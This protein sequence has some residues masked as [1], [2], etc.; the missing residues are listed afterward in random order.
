[1][2]VFLVGGTGLLGSAAAEELIRR[3]HSVSA[4]ALPPVPEGTALP[5]Q[6]TLD[7]KSYLTLSDDEIRKCMDGCEGFVFASGIDERMG[8]P[9]PI[10]DFFN[11]YNVAPLER[12]LRI[13]KECGVKHSVV[14]GSYFSYFDKIWP[15]LELYR[16]HPYIRSR[17]EQEKMALSFADNNF[18]VAIMELPYIF[19]GQQGREPVWTIIVKTLRGMKGVT[20]YP[21]GGTTMVTKKQVAQAIAGALEKTKGGQCWPIGWYNMSWKEFLSIVHENMGMPGRKI[22]TIPNWMLN[23]GIKSIEKKIREEGTEGGIYMPKFADLQSA[24]TF[25]DKSL[26]CIPLG[27]EDDDIRAAIGESIRLSV[28]AVDGKIKNIISMKGE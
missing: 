9:A 23:L 22:I 16:W 6:M 14:C 28:D 20:F 2:K 27:V 13:A 11:K 25:I 1:M 10:F 21:K 8:G 3:G 5:P 7:F 26:G 18:S 19:G 17:V 15:K 12:M 24:E 4:I